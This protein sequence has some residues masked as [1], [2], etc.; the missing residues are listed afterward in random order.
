MRQILSELE[1]KRNLSVCV[2]EMCVDD[3][4]EIV[5]KA[6]KRK[7]IGVASSAPFFVF[8]CGHMFHECCTSSEECPICFTRSRRRGE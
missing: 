6:H 1:Y 7:A 3:C 5:D 8:P 2:N 4:I